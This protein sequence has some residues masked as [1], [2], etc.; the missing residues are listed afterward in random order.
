MRPEIPLIILTGDPKI[1]ES[2][3]DAADAVLIKGTS[4]PRT[5]LQTVE[6][7]IRAA[8]MRRRGIS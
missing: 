6:T 4:N 8:S 2:V 3:H 1:P 5:M 7:L